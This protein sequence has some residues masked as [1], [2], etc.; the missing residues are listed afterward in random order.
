M[1][2]KPA[3]LLAV[4]LAAWVAMGASDENADHKGIKQAGLDYAEGWYAGDAERMERAVHP[5]LAKRVLMPGRRSGTGKI[6]HMS[7]MRLVQYT[8]NGSGNN[9]RGYDSETNPTD[10]AKA[11]QKQPSIFANTDDNTG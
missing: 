11:D 9:M 4:P 10:D 5:D 3:L 6:E 2:S 1:L 7:A 8:R